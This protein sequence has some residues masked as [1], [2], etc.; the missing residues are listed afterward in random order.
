MKYFTEL[1]IKGL[2]KNDKENDDYYICPNVSADDVKRI[3]DELGFKIPESYIELMLMRN[4]GM[5]KRT[6]FQ[7]KDD[8][9]KILKTLKCESL[10][11]I[12]DDDEHNCLLSKYCKEK[13]TAFEFGCW[14]PDS[15]WGN[16]H[17]YFDYSLCGPAGE[18][19]VTADVMKWF[20][21]HR[22][23]RPVTYEI[24]DTFKDFVI[25]LTSK[26][27]ILPFD[28]AWFEA[29]LFEAAKQTA[30]LLLKDH[31]QEKIVAFGFYTNDDGS[32][33]AIAANCEHHLQKCI[34]QNSSDSD[35]CKYATTEWAY[36]GIDGSAYCDQLTKRMEEYRG[37][38][39]TDSKVRAFRKQ[40]IECCV[41]ALSR[42]RE[43]PLM[44]EL[45]GGEITLMVGTTEGDIPKSQYKQIIKQLNG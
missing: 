26:P 11:G 22:K 12:W 8:A 10:A 19:R 41:N 1:D 23:A 24:A 33:I 17:F 43:S 39:L 35:F 18:P 25:G 15:G 31:P 7:V 3:E 16:C 29:G 14:N 37:M 34:A 42:L 44:F 40:I 32:M 27:V 9:G 2:W 38:L 36:E 5:L 45:F 20:P 28:F 4:G 21:E 30:A 13:D 6:I